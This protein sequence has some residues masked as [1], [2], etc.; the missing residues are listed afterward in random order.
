MENLKLFLNC[1]VGVPIGCT[2]YVERTEGGEIRASD[3]T[4][5]STSKAHNAAIE[6]ATE[7]L[8]AINKTTLANLESW[9]Q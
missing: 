8:E 6:R 2:C 7:R 5:C 9:K 3:I 1:F 4:D